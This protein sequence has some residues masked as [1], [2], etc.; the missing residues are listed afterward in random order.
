LFLDLKI[1]LLTDA[2]AALRSAEKLG[3]GRV[4]HLM[5][6][7]TFIK[8]LVRRRQAQVCKVDTTRNPAGSMTKY[9][10]RQKLA[11]QLSLI[12]VSTGVPDH[13]MDKLEQCNNWLDVKETWDESI[14]MISVE[15]EVQDADTREIMPFLGSIFAAGYFLG[16]MTGRVMCRR[17]SPTPQICD[18]TKELAPVLTRSSEE[19]LEKV[20]ICPKGG[21]RF[22]LSEDCGGINRKTDK[23]KCYTRCKLCSKTAWSGKR[24][25]PPQGKNEMD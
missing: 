15:D 12:G 14:N 10:D 13:H 1:V 2:T 3:P 18:A 5:T 20:Y 23:V 7:A 11:T 21:E 25:S 16:L 19:N 22:H 24:R 8:E 6:S 17:R 9:L 4:R